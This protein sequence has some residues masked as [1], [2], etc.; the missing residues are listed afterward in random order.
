M[1]NNLGDLQDSGTLVQNTTATVNG[2]ITTA[3][4]SVVIAAA[5]PNIFIG[6]T[7][8]G[9]GIPNANGITGATKVTGL[10]TDGKTLTLSNPVILADK[11]VLTFS[12]TY[13]LV[14]SS[15][16]SSATSNSQTV[17]ITAN[18]N[19]AV[20]QLVGV[21]YASGASTAPTAAIFVTAVASSTSITVSAP[22][23]ISNSEIITFWSPANANIAVDFVWK[24]LP[25]QPN[26]DRA[27]VPAANFVSTGTR[28]VADLKITDATSDGVVSTFTTDKDHGLVAGSVVNTG[29]Y[30]IG[31]T[32][33]NPTAGTTVGATTA[34]PN[35]GASSVTANTDNNT[36]TITFGT[37]HGI[38]PG[39]TVHI[40]NTIATSATNYTTLYQ[41]TYIAQPNTKTT[42]LVLNGGAPIT[43]AR[44]A[45]VLSTTGTSVAMPNITTAGTVTVYNYDLNQAVVASVPTTKT[46][47]VVNPFGYANS[48]AVTFS[49]KSATIEVLGDSNWNYNNGA[50][51]TGNVSTTKK[52]SDRLTFTK[53]T[54]TQSPS[55]DRFTISNTINGNAYETPVY[56]SLIVD[57]GFY[58]YPNFNTGKYLA[59]AAQAGGSVAKPYI[60][61]TASN[62]FA[63]TLTIG[64]S[65]VN[66][67]GFSNAL[68]NITGA[69][70]VAATS[71]NFVVSA[72]VTTATGGNGSTSQTGVTLT[73]ANSS[74]VVGQSVVAGGSVIGKVAA[75]SGTAL[76]LDTAASVAN[77]TSLTFLVPLGTALSGQSAA[78][79]VANWGVANYIVTAAAVDA[80]T[81]TKYI[82][83]AQN[84]LQPGDSVNI[85]GLSD[86]RF[87]T[88][89]AQSVS[90]ATATSFTLTG[91][92][93]LTG[94][95]PITGQTGK[96]EYANALSNVD[97]AY[98]SGAFGYL[99]PNVIGKLAALAEDALNDR[100][101]VPTNTGNTTSA[102][103][104]VAPSA[105]TRSV[106][107]NL[108]IVTTP[109][110]SFVAGDVVTFASVDASVNGDQVVVAAPDNTT[111]VIATSATSAVA[112][113][114]LTGGTVVGKIGYVHT[115]ASAAGTRLT[116]AAMNYGKWT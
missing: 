66:L 102:S 4:T 10:S 26:D 7:V 114:G 107:S 110:H 15:T 50:V 79:Q 93:A 45:G 42:S 36:I 81:N 59:T 58:G 40:T 19:V 54:D 70:V 17:A 100:G 23:S 56:D 64:T 47:T 73:A 108:A 85:T 13:S 27:T 65:K 34:T 106:G 67:S 1:A 80:T 97:G 31:G 5:N 20:G 111:L 90:S 62:N 78:V 2:A 99:V 115:Q 52:Q 84:N 69:T 49:S 94:V 113:T 75:I 86:S 92:T 98:S 29:V 88:S 76:T 57:S 77:S 38:L 11:T 61:V 63:E 43:A 112:L 91:Q 101:I 3:S 72:S 74:I 51:L 28:A 8:T 46:F 32:V 68:F 109:T 83:T 25:I 55:V 12:S 116:S 53:T 18:S 82:Y 35:T 105:I 14:T 33:A 41:G 9:F 60:L 89:S 6:Q 104:S 30:A 71:D 44:A 16:L 48:T 103:S 21:K 24:N 39:Q 87:N 22:V 96:V 95:A 37:N